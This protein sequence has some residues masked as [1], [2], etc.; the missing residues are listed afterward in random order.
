[1]AGFRIKGLRETQAAFRKA[2]KQLAKNLRAELKKAGEIVQTDAITRFSDIDANSAAGF[3]VRVRARGVKVEQSKGR[4]TGLRGD[5][6]ALQ[7][8]KALLPALESKR[9][10]VEHQLEDMLDKIARGF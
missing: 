6:G 8:R 5:Y 10:E 9:G 7:M 2:D 4:V 1:M 3:K